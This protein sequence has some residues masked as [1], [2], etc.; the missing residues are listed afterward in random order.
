V[1]IKQG[2]WCHSKTKKGTIKMTTNE[3]S[4]VKTTLNEAGG[5]GMSATN[6]PPTVIVN[7]PDG[8]PAGMDI[9]SAQMLQD[10]RIIILGEVNDE[11]A[12]R[13]C[14]QLKFLD[15]Q[16]QQTLDEQKA[17]LQEVTDKLKIMPD[18][19]VVLKQME[20]QLRQENPNA[21]DADIAAT[22]QQYAQNL[23]SVEMKNQLEASIAKGLPPIEIVVNSPGGQI[24]QGLA[25]YDAMRQCSC[26][27]TTIGTGWQ[28]SMGSIILSGGDKRY[29][30]P[31]SS[32]LVHQ[33]STGAVGQPT[34]V[35]IGIDSM[36]RLVD[37]LKTIFQDQTG[38]TKQYWG[39][40]LNRDTEFS[41]Q[42]A[43]DLGFIDGIQAVAK[44]ARYAS[45]RALTS[46]FDKAKGDVAAQFKTSAEIR[47][48][49]NS[50]GSFETSDVARAR[51][52]LAVALS[53]FPEFWTEGKK[54][55]MAEKAAATA[56]TNDNVQVTKQNK[57]YAPVL[58]V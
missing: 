51:P 3:F 14:T 18:K 15:E 6:L 10:R 44:P 52:E 46:A 37:K 43:L 45:D 5:G 23:P 24:Y 34:E 53:K 49:I 17:Q 32:L 29:M 27:I 33:G 25:I 40:V 31:D 57:T 16:G 13:I 2:A 55:E 30:T 47:A 54:A 7:G 21:S 1:V 9:Y 26:P 50:D 41:A 58:K 38:L 36:E 56:T 12:T 11:M 4:A 19:A 28:A 35:E 22:V 48:A 39:I 42:Q 8:K 20:A